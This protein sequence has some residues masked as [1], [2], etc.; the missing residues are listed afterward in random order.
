M[1]NQAS[2]LTKTFASVAAATALLG[3]T[4]C[5]SLPVASGTNSPLSGDD[6]QNSQFCM[7]FQA[8]QTKAATIPV[9][10]PKAE[11]YSAFG[12]KDD[13]T[14]RRLNK[15]EINKA[16]YGQATLNIT[17]EQRAE[18]QG[19]LN[20]LEGRAVTCQNV[21]SNRR[22][23]LTHTQVEKNGY[24]YTMTFIF[25]DA[26]LY[27]PVNVSGEP[28]RQKTNRGYL[29]DFNPVESAVR[30]ARGGL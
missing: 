3:M 6:Q 23:G 16:L 1:A 28:V 17:F 30:A 8:A 10:T 7:D 24:Q 19:F 9:G 27:D 21:H 22:F 20:T 14:L 5:S 26:V 15:E 2:Y 4:G 11:V 29:S 12:L 18:A 25:K 13:A